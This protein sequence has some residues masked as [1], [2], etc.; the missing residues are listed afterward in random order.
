MYP[1][2]EQFATFM[3][4]VARE[5]CDPVYGF[6]AFKITSKRVSVNL[7]T[8]SSRMNYEVV[9]C[10]ISHKL[11]GGQCVACLDYHDIT[12]C[13][14]FKAMLPVQRQQFA[15]EKQLC[16][17]CLSRSHMIAECRESVMC[18]I[19]GCKSRHSTFLH[20]SGRQRSMNPSQRTSKAP[21]PANGTVVGNV[22]TCSVPSK[23]V[24]LP[25][26]TVLVNGHEQVIAL[27][28]QG[29]TN[30]LISKRLADKLM[31]KGDS[32]KC[33]LNTVGMNKPIHTKYVKL[34]VAS[35]V[36]D[37]KFAIDHVLVVPDIPAESPP[38]E[39][40]LSHYPYLDDVSF[41]PLAVGTKADLLIGNDNPD[42][43]MPLD[44]R[45]STCEVRQPYAT[46]TRLGWVLQG[47]IEERM[48]DG[49]SVQVNHV[50]MD[51]LSV[52]VD[53]LWDIERQDESVCSWS[54]ED[55]QVHDMWQAETVHEDGRYT[56]PIP[57]RPGR[58]SFPNN[59]YLAMKR[60]E[61]TVM[62]LNQRGMTKSYGDGIH[63][64]LDDG[65]AESVPAECVLRDG[66]RVW[67]LPHH[68]VTSESKPGKVSIVFD[69]AA[70]CGGV[71]LNSE[72]YQGPDLCNKLLNV[73]LRF[74]QYD[75]ALMADIKAMYLQVRVPEIDRDCL[76]FLWL[77]DGEIVEYRMTSQLFGGV[78][79]AS[80][81]TYAIRRTL[82]DVE[83]STA[84][85][86][87]VSRCMYVDDLLRSFPVGSDA[88]RFVQEV[89]SALKKGGF[90][91]SK[92]VSN[93]T[94]VIS[95]VPLD[96]RADEVKIISYE[97]Q[98]KALGLKWDVGRD[99]FS[100]VKV[101]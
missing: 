66:G 68:A 74:R 23:K 37:G 64:L 99:T 54:V 31:L 4:K 96:D 11:R 12:Q 71:S 81:S 76:R 27:L 43:L 28:D 65:H 86:E 57:W 5:A 92:F 38:G 25:L 44:V 75:C 48:G 46:L 101:M 82:L 89:S 69:C 10:D 59:R 42:L 34:N 17:G 15:R 93:K 100:Y 47:P 45:R 67:Y 1:T 26:I 95:E 21:I 32:I 9:P 30:T 19:D 94:A 98:S 7:V 6:D 51:Q 8:D 39:L 35:I 58:P 40:T 83:A 80:S 29:S 50:M 91:L 70:K 85:K 18:L 33:S 3:D 90:H 63:K 49:S 97:M 52:R 20:V 78:W 53:K 13:G 36:N 41:G 60:L 56:V 16:Y 62:R 77:S 14:R 79:C 84:V 88:V 55:K 87:A 61:C 24:N 73:L 22:N 2:F 72:C